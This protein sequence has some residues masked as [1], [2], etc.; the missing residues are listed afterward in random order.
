V[1]VSPVV[2]KLIPPFCTTS[3][4]RMRGRDSNLIACRSYSAT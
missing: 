2:E 1:V 4:V 3:K